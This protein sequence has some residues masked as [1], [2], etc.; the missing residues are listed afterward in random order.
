MSLKFLLTYI[1]CSIEQNLVD[2]LKRLRSHPWIRKEL[3][4]RT[5]GFMYDIKSGK[6]QE[7]EA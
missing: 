5:H 2:D 3:A 6:L 1:L 4:E 7:V